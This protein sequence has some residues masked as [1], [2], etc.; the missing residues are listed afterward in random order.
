[1]ADSTP[2]RLFCAGSAA[3]LS[4]FRLRPGQLLAGVKE[5]GIPSKNGKLPWGLQPK[6]KKIVYNGTGKKYLL[7][8]I[9]KVWS[10][11]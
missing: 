7:S 2:I 3:S 11:P 6:N 8:C 5:N 1:M 9:I 10:T 4:P